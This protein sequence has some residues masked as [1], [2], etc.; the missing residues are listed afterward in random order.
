[1]LSA[2]RS[3]ACNNGGGGSRDICRYRMVPSACA[4]VSK[5]SVLAGV[6]HGTV[7]A[8]IDAVVGSETD[9]SVVADIHTGT[10]PE[11]KEAPGAEQGMEAELVAVAVGYAE[12]STVG[13]G[14][15]AKTVTSA[16]SAVG[17]WKEKQA[18]VQLLMLI[19]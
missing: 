15:S 4:V 10:G 11:I 18:H 14:A 8:E 16:G 1:M 6:Q 17:Q 12:T 7:V 19:W 5:C 9:V 13:V 2:G 3:T